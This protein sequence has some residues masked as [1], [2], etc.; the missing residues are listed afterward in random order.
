MLKECGTKWGAFWLGV[1]GVG[2]W[3]VDYYFNSANFI[4]IFWRHFVAVCETVMTKMRVPD[5]T[6]YTR[7]V[8]QNRSRSHY[9][10]ATNESLQEQL[11]EKQVFGTSV[12]GEAIWIYNALL[13]TIKKPRRPRLHNVQ[14]RRHTWI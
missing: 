8:S 1:V 6:Q 5:Y 13:I 2:V 10:N 11:C 3:W 12:E 14:Y 7:Q 9:P 4:V